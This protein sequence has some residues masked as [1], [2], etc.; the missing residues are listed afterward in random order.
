MEVKKEDIKYESLYLI[1]NYCRLILENCIDK[2][3]NGGPL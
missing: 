1:T 3:R 2:R